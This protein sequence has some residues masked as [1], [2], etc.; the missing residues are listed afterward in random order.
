MG[1]AIGDVMSRLSFDITDIDD[2]LEVVSCDATHF[3]G[4]CHEGLRHDATFGTDDLYP[5]SPIDLNMLAHVS[6]DEDEH[7]DNDNAPLE[8]VALIGEDIYNDSEPE[9]FEYDV[10]SSK[11][12]KAK[13]DAN[14][15]INEENEIHKDRYEM[16]IDDF[17]TYSGGEGDY[18]SGRRS[19]LNKLKKAFMQGEGDGSKY[20]FYY[21]QV[22]SS[23]KEVKDRVYLHYVETRKEL[24]LVRND[25]L[26]VRAMCFGKT[27]MYENA[28]QGCEN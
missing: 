21:A 12:E 11:N 25:K 17:D 7:L 5:P 15:M 28:S 20:A 2:H 22:F 3:S 13:D 8:N 24:K 4:S 16:D 14:M 9:D 26:R 1:D 23:S 27:P 6:T 10:D 18:T 19:A